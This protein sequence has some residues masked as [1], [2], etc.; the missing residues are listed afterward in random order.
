MKESNSDKNNSNVRIDRWLKAARFYKSRNSAS[1]AIE[2]GEVKLNGER[3]K[4]AKTVKTG[5]LIT[6]RK[7]KYYRDFIVKG[8]SSRALPA[9]LA[10]ELYEE[11]LP[12]GITP[13]MKEM[14]E[15]LKNQE[16]QKRREWKEIKENKKKRR[17]TRRF[18][19]G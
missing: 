4:P 15:I 16:K 13:E 5:D 12:E 9:N 17:E 19:Y 6:I 1:E 14:I 3:T 2:S 7:G 18:K 11:K 10:K 8:I